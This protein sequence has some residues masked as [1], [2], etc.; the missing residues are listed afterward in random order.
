MA[1]GTG[2]GTFYMCLY[3]GDGAVT[4]NCIG[5]CI[6]IDHGIRARIFTLQLDEKC[7]ICVYC[8]YTTVFVVLVLVLALLGA[9]WGDRHFQNPGIGT[10]TFMH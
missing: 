2:S 8:K 7:K 6:G 10:D 1:S 3:A 4:G 9:Y 5:I